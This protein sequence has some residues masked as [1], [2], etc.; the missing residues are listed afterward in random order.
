MKLTWFKGTTLRVYL[1]GTIILIDGAKAPA[2]IDVVELNS[3]ADHS[4][5]LDGAGLPIIDSSRWAPARAGSLLDEKPAETTLLRL[6]EGVLLIHAESEAPLVISAGAVPPAGRWSR[7]AVVIAFDAATAAQF[8]AA[9]GPRMV[10]LALPSD[11]AGAAFDLL[12]ADLGD[13]GLMLLEPGFA[14]EV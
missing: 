2:G 5:G 14:L 13:T 1:A 8:V 3:G 12:R 11:A 7:D 9:W 10:A 4:I 6:G